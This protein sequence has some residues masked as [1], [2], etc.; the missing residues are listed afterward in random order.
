MLT[1]SELRLV[2]SKEMNIEIDSVEKVD[3]H[4][5]DKGYGMVRGIEFC[6]K[7]V[8]RSKDIILGLHLSL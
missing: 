7:F 5:F 3:K 1:C 2:L 8:F 4:I 6:I